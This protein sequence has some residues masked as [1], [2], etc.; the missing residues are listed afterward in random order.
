MPGGTDNNLNILWMC[1]GCGIGADVS[2]CEKLRIGLILVRSGVFGKTSAF[3]LEKDLLW[4]LQPGSC[5]L[6]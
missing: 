6:L 4:L 2:F 5:R 3:L 1:A